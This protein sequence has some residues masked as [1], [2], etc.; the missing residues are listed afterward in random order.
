[1]SSKEL[2]NKHILYLDRNIGK[3]D[4]PKLLKS[5][6]IDFKI[7]DDHLPQNANDESWVKLCSENNWIAITLDNRLQHN[8]PVKLTAKENPTAIF[9][10]NSGNMRGVELGELLVNNYEKIIKFTLKSKKSFLA[11]LS[12]NGNISLKKFP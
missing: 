7:H 11:T 1:M 10:I 3:H 9:V 5:S 6:N 8:M 4:V 12:R 2:P